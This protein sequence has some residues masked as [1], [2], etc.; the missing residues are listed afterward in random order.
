[1]ACDA[2]SQSEIVVPLIT[3]GRVRGVLDVDSPLRAR[4][5]DLERSLFEKIARRIS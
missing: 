5:S 3:D 2:A 4:F 1:I